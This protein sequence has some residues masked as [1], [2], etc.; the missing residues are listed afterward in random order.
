MKKK[1]FE[2][3]FKKNLREVVSMQKRFSWLPEFT[4]ITID[5]IE[6]V[7]A[8]YMEI[9]PVY[10][11]QARAALERNSLFNCMNKLSNEKDKQALHRQIAESDIQSGIVC[12]SHVRRFPDLWG[13]VQPEV[14]KFEAAYGAR[15]F[16]VPWNSYS[17]GKALVRR[18]EIDRELLVG[19]SVLHIAPEPELAAWFERN[20][21]SL[22][23]KY[24]TAGIQG[25]VHYNEDLTA[26]TMS[27]GL[28]DWVICHRVLEHIFDDIS[29]IKEIKRVLKPHGVFNVSVPESMQR[30]EDEFWGI[31]DVTH[32][33]H[34]RHYG[35]NFQDRLGECGFDSKVVEHALSVELSE[36]TYPLRMYDASARI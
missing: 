5:N 26:L 35:A 25:K 7:R 32:H 10:Y 33:R 21:P 1:Y 20:A 27:D 24:R 30:P 34:F 19:T 12:S 22:N 18:F 15:V 2:F 13:Q 3:L 8:L 6:D 28:Y 14:R 23:I 11:P 29:A 4:N 16:T 9:I 17:R 31:E 36:G